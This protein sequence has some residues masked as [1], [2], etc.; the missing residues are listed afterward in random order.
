MYK[1]YGDKN[2]FEGGRYATNTWDDSY[3]IILC[4]YVSDMDKYRLVF[5]TIDINDSWIDENAIKN[6]AGVSRS[7]LPE[8][9]ALACAEYYDIENFGTPEY[10][11]RNDVINRMNGINTQFD[12]ITW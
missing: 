8:Q 9:Y 7:D 6:F 5:G 3:D 4:D 12:E 2:F 1:N 10:L 11:T